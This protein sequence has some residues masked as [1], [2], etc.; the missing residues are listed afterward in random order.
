M[1]QAGALCV[2]SAR[3]VY[4]YAAAQCAPVSG[5]QAVSCLATD[6]GVQVSVGKTKTLVQPALVQCADP[7]D[8]IALAWLVVGVLVVAWAWRVISETAK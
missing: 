5:G 3:A 2:D 6:S 1:Y 8:T 7:A 4:N